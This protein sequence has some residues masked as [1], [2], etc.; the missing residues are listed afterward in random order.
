MCVQVSHW[1]DVELKPLQL[2]HLYSYFPYC[3]QCH[4][5]LPSAVTVFQV[6]ALNKL[7]EAMLLFNAVPC[8]F[9]V[10]G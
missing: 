4:H 9:V 3:P 6:V 5:I 1:G 7:I 8:V 10:G 2:L